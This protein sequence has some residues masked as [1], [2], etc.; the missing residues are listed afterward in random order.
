MIRFRVPEL[1][2]S[3]FTSRLTLILFLGLLLACRIV[4]VDRPQAPQTPPPSLARVSSLVGSG[5]PTRIVAGTIA[6]DA[7]VVQMDWQPQV[8]WGQVVS[9]WNVPDNEAAWH[10]NSAIPG[11]GGN[12]VISGHNDSLGGRVF[13]RLEDLS[14]G[15]R[16]TLWNDR[17]VS[18]VYEVREK[19][20]I[21][22]LGASTE[23][24]ARLETT[25]EPTPAEQLTLITCW[26]N[27]TNTHRLIIIASPKHS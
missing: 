2:A 16:I 22:V 9:E 19:R 5:I 15:D 24:L 18:F 20:F 12:I 7:P 25:M 6:L 8:E 14:V 3:K 17:N 13:A 10:R 26:P 11:D 21:R 1:L 27:W 4:A 23:T